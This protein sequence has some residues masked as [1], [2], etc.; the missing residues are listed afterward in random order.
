MLR[1]NQLRYAV[2]ESRLPNRLCFINH[3]PSAAME[4]QVKRVCMVSGR[5]IPVEVM[6]EIQ[7]RSDLL[8]Y[9]HGWQVHDLVMV[10]NRRFF[11]GRRAYGEGISRDIV[12]V[13][14]ARASFAFGATQRRQIRRRSEASKT[15]QA[16]TAAAGR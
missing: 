16:I 11:H 8:T 5:E 9:E 7:A 6:D 10:D 4:P 3:L 12:N 14:T 13:Q 1:L 2:H 15:Q